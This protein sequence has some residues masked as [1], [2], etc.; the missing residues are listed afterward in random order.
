MS[1]ITGPFSRATVHQNWIAYF[2]LCALEGR[3]LDIYGFKGKQVRD[4]IDARDLVR[5][6]DRFAQS[7]RP[8]EVYNLGGGP[9]NAVSCLETIERIES[10]TGRRI[11]WSLEEGREADHR[12]YVTDLRKVK[13]HYPGWEVQIGID[14][15]FDNL[16]NWVRETAGSSV[17]SDIPS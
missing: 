7:P 1:C 4:N 10:M 13:E 8:G 9:T 5:A 3:H 14:Q 12:I 2:M 17:G 11:D 6:F 15:I 16:L